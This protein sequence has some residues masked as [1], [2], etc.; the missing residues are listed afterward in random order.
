[1][2]GACKGT[3]GLLAG[4]CAAAALVAAQPVHAAT[5]PGQ[6]ASGPGGS[7]YSHAG[8]RVTAGGTGNDAWYVFEP[9]G[10]QPAAAP[11]AVITHGYFEYAGH[12]QMEELIRHTVRKG[13]VVIYPRW[14]TGVADPCPGPF[15]IEP[16]ITSTVNGISGGLQYLRETPGAVQ[17][18]L[19]R[20][21]YFGFS[22]GGIITANMLNR[23]VSLGLPR[24]R[25]IFL[26]D[27]H[28][29]ALNGHGEP[30]LDSSLAGIPADVKLQC[31][32]SQQ[33]VLREPG[34]EQ[35]SCNAIFPKLRH[36][37]L[38]NKDIVMTFADTHGTPALG[39]PHGVCAASAGNANAYDWNFCWKVWDGLR[40]AAYFGRNCRFALGDTREHSSNGRWSDG[41]PIARLKIQD[42]GPI[43]PGSPDR[44]AVGG[45]CR[46][47]KIRLRAQKRQVADRA[48]VR[49]TIDSDGV[50][51]LRGKVRGAGAKL[52]PLRK[53]AKAGRRV[54]L[55]LRLRGGVPEL[56]GEERIVVEVRVIARD[57]EG[58]TVKR[59]AV[60]LS[61]AQQRASSRE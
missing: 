9:T 58:K 42:A 38:A 45:G 26:E 52:R 5:Q 7:D 36:I 35:S 8:V 39:A 25:A 21:S 51:I 13:N 17:A 50:V 59:R 40:D 27:P 56:A 18:Q 19:Q 31:H 48:R 54:E 33:G 61:G 44:K 30:A 53:K 12:A 1:V 29:G 24:P 41:V 49:V 10:P 37:P 43:G 20:T 60:R 34:K 15:N 46:G 16:C 4:L 32:S 3:R 28:D 23:Y 47:P 11:L 14:Q 6:P 2:T 57:R 22:F 55:P